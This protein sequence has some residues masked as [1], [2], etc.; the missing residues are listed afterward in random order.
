[1]AVEMIANQRA[2]AGAARPASDP[3]AKALRFAVGF[4]SFLGIWTSLNVYFLP[5]WLYA[6]YGKYTFGQPLLHHNLTAHNPV[7]NHFHR[8]VGVTYIVIALMQFTPEL[9]RA[10]P[11]LHRWLGRV[12]VSIGFLVGITGVG[13]TGSSFGGW[14][15]RMANIFFGALL[16]ACLVRALLLAREKRFALHREWMIRAFAIS[17][18]VHTL[19]VLY[20]IMTYTLPVMTAVEILTVCTWLGYCVNLLVAESWINHTR[21][22]ARKPRAQQQDAAMS[23]AG[24]E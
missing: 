15:E 5:G 24:G 12:F 21:P 1:M 20:G 2:E 4:L 13:M 23:V 3:W 7:L 11:Y 8:A 18:G 6:W 22:R 16:L 14:T 19:R 10:R 17:M 9:R